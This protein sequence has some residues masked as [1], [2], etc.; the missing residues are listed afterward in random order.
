[1]HESATHRPSR[2]EGAAPTTTTTKEGAHRGGCLADGEVRPPGGEIV[3][4][5]QGARRRRAAVPRGWRLRAW[6]TRKHRKQDPPAVPP[7]EETKIKTE[8][9]KTRNVIHAS[10]RRKTRQC[11]ADSSLR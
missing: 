2:P 10:R 8:R 1:M 6:G 11:L 7:R 5:P 3:G 9:I 4:S